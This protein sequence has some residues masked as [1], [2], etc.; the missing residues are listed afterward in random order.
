[1]AGD[2]IR[3]DQGVCIYELL[4]DVGQLPILMIGKR[5][6]IRALKLNTNRE[7]ITLFPPVKTGLPCMPSSFIEGYKL[8][9][10]TRALN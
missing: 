1:M 6:I 10:T 3:G 7:V 5:L 9:D 8:N 2:S 4:C